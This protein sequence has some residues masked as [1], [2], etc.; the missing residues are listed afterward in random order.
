[1]AWIVPLATCAGALVFYL[2]TGVDTFL[3]SL[4]PLLPVLIALFAGTCVAMVRRRTGPQRITI[5]AA[6]SLAAAIT[7]LPTLLV[8][9]R[10]LKDFAR[11]QTWSSGHPSDAA[12]GEAHRGR[13]EP[14][15]WVGLC[16]Q[17]Q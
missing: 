3:L 4:L 16:W 14:L 12:K 6:I 1:M 5:T 13:F 7:M 9:G 2:F 8:L 10:P 15:G 17:R 11:F